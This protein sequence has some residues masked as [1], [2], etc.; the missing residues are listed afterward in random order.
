[1]EGGLNTA[2][3]RE[4]RPSRAFINTVFTVNFSVGLGLYIILFLSAP[5][6]A[7]FYDN[8]IV[9]P[10]IKIMGL[11]VFF[12][13]IGLVHQGILSHTLNFKK[14]FYLVL[15]AYIISGV[16]AIF[17]AYNGAGVYSLAAKELAL[18]GLTTLFLVIKSKESV[19]F[20]FHKPIF[21][22]IF[23]FGANMTLAGLLT[24]VYTNIYLTVI[25]K[26]YSPHLLGLH[27]QALKLKN[28]ISSNLVT[29]IQK[30]SYPAL[31]KLQDEPFKLKKVYRRIITTTSH[32]VIPGMVL[33]FFTATEVIIVLFG[34]NWLEAAPMLQIL[35]VGGM[36]FNLVLIYQNL[37]KVL[38]KGKLYLRLEFIQKIIMGIAIVVGL[39]Y[40]FKYFLIFIVAGQLL[41]TIM[42]TL[43]SGKL[44][45]YTVKEQ[46]SDLIKVI[47]FPLLLGGMLYL[48]KIWFFKYYENIVM[49]LFLTGIMMLIYFVIITL[50]FYKGEINSFY[51]KKAGLNMTEK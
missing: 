36:F 13:S 48:Y 32:F 47:P 14:E 41:S 46:L 3:I 50:L 4:K 45:D 18:T 16:I 40:N 43:I 39:S 49:F 20:G 23:S 12:R 19:R 2:L 38:G 25:G 31:S 44:I 29:A 33:L 21:K 51:N 26:M 24:S 28:L 27:N 11:S 15:P 17:M 6:I 42:Y 5:F 37:L 1:M 7:D 34:A 10:L 8:Q 30:V 9:D 22:K 35:A